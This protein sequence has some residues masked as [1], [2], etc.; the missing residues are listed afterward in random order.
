MPRAT[1][2]CP[3]TLSPMDVM[4]RARASSSASTIAWRPY[5]WPRNAVSTSTR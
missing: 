1:V 2:F 3:C 5:P 4:P